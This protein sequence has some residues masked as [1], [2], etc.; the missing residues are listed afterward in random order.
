MAL[1]MDFAVTGVTSGI[2]IVVAIGMFVVTGVPASGWFGWHPV[3]MTAAF[4]CLMPSGRW[5]YGLD[6]SWGADQQKKRVAHRAVMGS[7][8]ILMLLGYVCILVAHSTG[9]QKSYFGYD[10][11]KNEWKE[12]KRVAH[13]W[14]GFCVILLTLAQG[15]MGACKLKSL[16][17]TG[18]R[19]FTFHGQMGKVIIGMAIVNMLLAVWFWGWGTGFKLL[20]VLLALCCGAIGTVPWHFV[21]PK[22]EE[23]PLVA[24]PN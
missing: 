15:V 22:A 12:W 5:I 21:A 11:K 4:A 8:A 9:G 17:T 14:L 16:N 10:F 20:T 13:G 24:P 7:A 3:L 6:A 1:S 2:V 23:C 18:E 19:I